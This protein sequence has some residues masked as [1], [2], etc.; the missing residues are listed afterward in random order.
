MK[1]EGLS[2]RDLKDLS[3][4]IEKNPELDAFSDKLIELNKGEGYP[5]PPVEW[6]AGSIATDL[7]TSLNKKGRAK[8]YRCCVYYSS[9]N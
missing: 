9:K 3:N 5:A 2:K 4:I 7:R 6:L 8:Y 1:I